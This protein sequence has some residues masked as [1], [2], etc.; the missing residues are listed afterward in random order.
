MPF[1]E[2]RIPKVLP[3][4]LS[5]LCWRFSNWSVCF[6]NLCCVFFNLCCVILLVSNLVFIIDIVWSIEGEAGL[7]AQN[8]EWGGTSIHHSAQS[9]SHNC[10]GAGQRGGAH[11]DFPMHPSYTMFSPNRYYLYSTGATNVES[12]QPEE[13]HSADYWAYWKRWAIC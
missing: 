9:L 8:T 10:R 3:G 1:T 6:F 4:V 13:S 2:V 5:T 7:A 12:Q 11:D